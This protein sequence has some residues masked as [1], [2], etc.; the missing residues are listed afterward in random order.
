MHPAAQETPEG[1][2]LI[3]QQHSHAKYKNFPRFAIL[4]YH[5]FLKVYLGFID[6]YYLKC[7]LAAVNV[8]PQASRALDTTL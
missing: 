6:I 3:N 8:P 1:I 4:L 7:L 5:V 2:F